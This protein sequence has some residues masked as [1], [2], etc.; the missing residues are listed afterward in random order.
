MT[1]LPPLQS[2]LQNQDDLGIALAILLEP[3]PALINHL[4]PLVFNHPSFR[5]AESYSAIIDLTL[6]IL[7]GWPHS[8]QANVIASHPR[9]GEVKGLSALSSKEQASNA[10]PPEVLK[11]LEVLNELY[12]KRYPGLRYIIFVD[13]R[14]REQIVPLMEE[15]VGNEDNIVPFSAESTEWK[16]E[17]ERAVQDVGRI[18]KSRLEKMGIE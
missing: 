5:S 18:A 16:N 6:E 3:S 11:R 9:I 14:S 8:E 13:G 7:Q 12:E 1:S 4:A 10:T 2:T 17:L 15:K